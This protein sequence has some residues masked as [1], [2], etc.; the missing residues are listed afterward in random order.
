MND[1][2]VKLDADIVQWAHAQA[3]A[4]GTSVTRL[5]SSMLRE[6]MAQGGAM[7]QKEEPLPLQMRAGFMLADPEINCGVFRSASDD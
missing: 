3:A 6:R 7:L 4:K 2:F 1:S 5:L